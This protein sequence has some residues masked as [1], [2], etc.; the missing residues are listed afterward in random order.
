[1][2]RKTPSWISGFAVPTSDLVVM[3]PA[4]SPSYPDDSLEDVLRHEVAHVLIWRA[5]DGRSIPR[6]FNEGLAMAVE[7]RRRFEDQTQLLYQLVTGS[8]TTLDQL[9]RLFSGGQSDQTRAYALAG[10]FVHDVFQRHGPAAC[11]EI[12]MR[13]KRGAQFEVA[14]ADVTGTTPSDA[15]SEFWKRQR[16]WTAWVPIVTSPATLWMVV[17][18]IALLAIYMRRRRN[19]AME[20]QWAKEEEDDDTFQKIDGNQHWMRISAFSKIETCF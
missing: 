17:T 10:A 2:A 5:S 4:R 18:F 8:R 20:H 12:L 13:V 15:E 3:F 16:I 19:R 11:G 14:F 6:W 7:R 9:D 1:L